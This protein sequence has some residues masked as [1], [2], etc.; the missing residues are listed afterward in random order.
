MEGMMN[1][2]AAELA[3]Q[4][5]EPV[6]AQAQDSEAAETP[7]PPI[8]VRGSWIHGNG[9]FAAR[10]IRKGERIMEYL[11]EHISEDEAMSRYDD[12]NQRRHHT[13]LF[14]LADGTYIDGGSFGNEARY[15]NHSCEPNCE[16]FEEEGR[17]F[18]YAIKRVREGDELTYDYKLQR[19]GKPQK[20]W[21]KLYACGCGSKN[22][23]G[24]MLYVEPKKGKKDKK[25]KKA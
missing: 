7:R 1:G 15:I 24:T 4:D 16:A 22:C 9:I 10:D 18:I 20:S 12:D 14:G 5:A 13:F 17:I 21:K 11:G 25:G 2:Q 19:D 23:R 8:E 3:A 6:M